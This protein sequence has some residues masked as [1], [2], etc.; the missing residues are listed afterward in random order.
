MEITKKISQ[1]IILN[2]VLVFVKEIKGKNNLPYQ[3]GYIVASNHASNLD[4][5]LICAIIFKNSGKIIRYIGKKEALKNFLGRFI[6]RTFDVIPIDRNSNTKTPLKEAINALKKKEIVGI[7]P[8]A[9]RTYDG[10]IHKGRT[11]VARLVL[12]SNSRIVPIA[13]KNTYSLWPRDKKFPKF[14][15]IAKINIGKPIKPKRSYTKD[16]VVSKEELRQLTDAVMKKIRHLYSN[17]K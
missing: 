3:G 11:G 16:N 9:T 12:F 17:L 5:F 6:Y 15:R 7:F 13:I 1:K 10:G 14:K 8:E 2:S 4:P